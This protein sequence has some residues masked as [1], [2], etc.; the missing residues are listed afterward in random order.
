MPTIA[1][2]LLKAGALMVAV[3]GLVAIPA[4]AA[5]KQTTLGPGA[6]V[7][8]AGSDIYCT[9][10][11]TKTV[12]TVA[13]FHLPA[14]AS[15]SKRTGYAVFGSDLY[16][17]VTPPGTNTPTKILPEPSFKSVPKVNGRVTSSKLVEINEGDLAPVQ[18]TH[19]GILVTKAKGGGDAI[20]VV[21]IDASGGPIVGEITAGISNHYVTLSR[22]T[23][24]SSSTVIYHHKVS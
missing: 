24:K 15:S 4:A 23:G 17:G 11:K 16:A 3:A 21:Y 10:V 12:V 8:L 7:R 2:A 13:C 9:V 19:M 1:R 22:V 18:G 20:G 5:G 6:V 14:G